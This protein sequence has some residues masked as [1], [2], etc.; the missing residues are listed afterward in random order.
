MMRI[1]RLRPLLALALVWLAA[2]PGLAGQDRPRVAVSILPVHAIVAAVMAGVAAP[3][4]IVR[5]AGSPHSYAMRPSAARRLAGAELVFWVGGTLETFLAKPLTALG[6][7]AKVVTLIERAAIARLPTRAGGVHK[8]GSPH[9][10]RDGA[11]D[12]ALDPHLWLDPANAVTIAGIAAA[13]LTAIDPARR[14]IYAANADRVSA[15]IGALDAELRAILA[16][17]KQIPYVVFHDAYQYF[18]RRYGLNVVGSVTLGPERR[19]GARRLREIREEIAVVGAR[20]LFSEPQFGPALVATVGEG[21]G[22]RTAVLDPLGAD[23][24]PGPDAYFKLMRRLARA[25][26]DCLAASD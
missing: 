22:V 18:E 10:H 15:R 12:H 6:A 1:L 16:P 5:G 21:R 25:L 13:E 4:L 26:R 9:D 23:L 11:P 19:P 7:K 3:D 8:D 20:C 2:T 24:E 14:A 17:V